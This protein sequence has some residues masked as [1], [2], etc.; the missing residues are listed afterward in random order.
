MAERSFG[1]FMINTVQCVAHLRSV[2][3]RNKIYQTLATQAILGGAYPES[4][5]S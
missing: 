1:S 4:N 2:A 3:Q 5:F